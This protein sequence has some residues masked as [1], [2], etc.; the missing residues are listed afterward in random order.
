MFYVHM[1]RENVPQNVLVKTGNSHFGSNLIP[2][3]A[4]IDINTTAKCQ[5]NNM[6]CVVIC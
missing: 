5:K 3:R 6:L 2:Q 4:V 1:V